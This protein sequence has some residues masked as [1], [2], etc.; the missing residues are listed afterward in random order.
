[1]QAVIGRGVS[2]SHRAN[3]K[4]HRANSDSK[5]WAGVIVQTVIL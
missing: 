1:M 5:E 3:S 4:S 2:R